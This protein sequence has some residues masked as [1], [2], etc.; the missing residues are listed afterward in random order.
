[1]FRYHRNSIIDKL[2][3]SGISLQILGIL[4]EEQAPH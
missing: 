3:E 2:I 4:D 1:M